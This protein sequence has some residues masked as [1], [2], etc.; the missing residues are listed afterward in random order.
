MQIGSQL[1]AP[2]CNSTMYN[3]QGFEFLAKDTGVS[4]V[5]FCHLNHIVDDGKKVC[6]KHIS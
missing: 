4:F 5:D 6:E 3:S 1:P 2:L